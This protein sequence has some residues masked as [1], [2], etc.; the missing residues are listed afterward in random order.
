[1]IA[2]LKGFMTAAMRVPETLL[3]GAQAAAQASAACAAPG[4]PA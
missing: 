1:M 2:P 3:L 4:T